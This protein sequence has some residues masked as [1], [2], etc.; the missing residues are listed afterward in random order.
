MTALSTMF[1]DL[2][3]YTMVHD[4]EDERPEIVNYFF[5]NGFNKCYTNTRDIFHD[6][7]RVD[8]FLYACSFLKYGDDIERVRR[9]VLTTILRHC[10][11]SLQVSNNR[12]GGRTVVGPKSIYKN[13]AL[14]PDERQ[15]YINLYKELIGNEPP[16][17]ETTSSTDYESIYDDPPNAF[18]DPITAEDDINMESCSQRGFVAS[19][20]TEDGYI[21]ECISK[22]NLAFWNSREKKNRNNNIMNLGFNMGQYKVNKPDWIRRQPIFENIT[23]SNAN[24]L[25]IPKPNLF[26]I[27]DDTDGNKKLVKAKFVG[28]SP[29]VAVAQESMPNQTRKRGLDDN[30][31]KSQR[32][33]TGGRK[34]LKKARKSKTKRPRK[35]HKNYSRKRRN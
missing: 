30:S 10:Y 21:Y 5:N 20:K 31:N 7:A 19:M 6:G 27:Q 29:P 23:S 3:T 8:L 13:K 17:T 11:Q 22:Q 2:S 4:V 35:T 33:R 34:T 1:P 15:Y 26:L 12:I 9:E 16:V 18:Y 24:R 32:K 25:R 14:N 28:K